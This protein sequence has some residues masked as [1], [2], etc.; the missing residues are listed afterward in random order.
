[1]NKKFH[2][3]NLIQSLSK[4]EKKNFTTLSN[5]HK[6]NDKLITLYKLIE[7]GK[8]ENYIKDKYC[9]LYPTTNF[10]VDKDL[11]EKFVLKTLRW[12]YDD[13]DKYY[14]NLIF[15]KFFF[16]KNNHNLAKRYLNKAIPNTKDSQLYEIEKLNIELLKSEILFRFNTFSEVLNHRKENLIP[17]LKDYTKQIELRQIIL[18]L[19]HDIIDSNT[20][21]NIIALKQENKKNYSKTSLYLYNTLMAAIAYKENKIADCIQYHKLVLELFEHNLPTF[22]V[23]NCTYAINVIIKLSLLHNLPEN[24]EYYIDKMKAFDLEANLQQEYVYINS[25]IRY[26]NHYKKYDECNK[27]ISSNIVVSFLEK[28]KLNNTS[29]YNA[30]IENIFVTKFYT[31]DFKFIKKTIAELTVL[32]TFS[33]YYYKYLELLIALVN[34]NYISYDIQLI[35]LHKIYLEL[36]FHDNALH[37]SIIT[38]LKTLS[39]TAE[40]NYKTYS[41]FNKE[42]S[43]LKED[44]TEDSIVGFSFKEALNHIFNLIKN[45]NNS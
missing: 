45:K 11:L 15:S 34:I 25:I 7:T 2:L 40:F 32:D 30:T 27:F 42:L 23:K 33:N 29:F 17:Y 4:S 13:E 43:L 9:K 3:Q 12:Y 1:M 16:F 10:S 38:F 14:S 39:K 21:E 20:N 24:Y 35:A 19:D 8:E 5:L 6:I 18:E 31:N 44:I 22:E 37:N 28:T 26:F 36:K 41:E